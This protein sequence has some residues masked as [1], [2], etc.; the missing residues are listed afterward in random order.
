MRTMS[1]LS[2]YKISKTKYNNNK[3]L[4]LIRYHKKFKIEKLVDFIRV[5]FDEYFK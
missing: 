3:I 4:K 5:H 1:S 2:S